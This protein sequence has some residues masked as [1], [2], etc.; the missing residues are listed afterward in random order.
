MK[1]FLVKDAR[2]VM[3][4]GTLFPAVMPMFLLQ[5]GA[6][7]ALAVWTELEGAVPPF[8][9]ERAGGALAILA[10]FLGILVPA[11]QAA[12]A[13]NA[14]SSPDIAESLASAPIRPTAFLL[15]KGA[16]P[17]A[18]GVA[19]QAAL[20]PAWLYL[21]GRGLV[22]PEALLRALFALVLVL[23]VS[24]SLGLAYFRIFSGQAAGRLPRWTGLQR[25]ALGQQ[26]VG[27]GVI[28]ILIV[29]T[30]PG[31]LTAAAPGAATTPGLSLVMRVLDAF[32]PAL[33][34]RLLA[35]G[36]PLSIFGLAL[37]V[38]L[39]TPVL[40]G[41]AAAYFY[42][43]GVAAHART[44]DRER[45]WAWRVGIATRGAIVLYAVGAVWV[46]G[47][48][49]AC[50]L[51]GL[52]AVA[53]GIVGLAGAQR[54]EENASAAAASCLAAGVASTLF[55]GPSAGLFW[56]GV[57]ACAAAASAALPLARPGEYRRAFAIAVVVVVCAAAP[58]FALVLHG[59]GTFTVLARLAG[60]LACVT[61]TLAVPSLADA[62][63]GTGGSWA[64]LVKE[65]PEL[66][67][68]P[69][70]IASPVFLGLIATAAIVRRRMSD[71]APAPGTAAQ[72]AP[73]G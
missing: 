69:P 24:V 57:A 58:L 26:L 31:L 12:V 36:D 73:G 30:I 56:I 65:I 10:F 17:L 68:V 46:E 60:A 23:P 67:A 66:G 35:S 72:A 45:L 38:W 1:A 7:G 27:F 14:E 59:I 52:V 20:L 63:L 61:P 18:H 64:T 28:G 15:G 16:L 49:I 11:G 40:L 48:A 4:G 62:T 6:A 54:R 8:V 21:A 33:P 13:M 53:F 3:R 5:A 25:Q 29:H 22:A 19:T 41:T 51:A 9:L 39:I 44:E 43:I 55:H 50:T 70:W 37:P 2:L 71:A 47:V 32:R 34:G 42:A